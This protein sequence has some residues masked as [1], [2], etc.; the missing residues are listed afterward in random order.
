MPARGLTV[1][2]EKSP[3]LRGFL[4]DGRAGERRS[5]DNGKVFHRISLSRSIDSCRLRPRPF[6]SLRAGFMTHRLDV[7]RGRELS[8]AGAFLPSSGCDYLTELFETGRWRRFHSER[9]F[10]ENIQEA[11]SA[12]ETWRDLL[13]R[14]ASRDNSAVDISWLGRA[15]ATLPPYRNVARSGPSASVAAGTE[16]GRTAVTRS[17]RSARKPFT[18]RSKEAP[19]A[20]DVPALVGVETSPPEPTPD[21]VAMHERYPLLRNAL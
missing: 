1:N 18:C 7:A 14:E 12:V 4:S 21:I 11:K 17:S 9:A 16:P 8:R 19:S 5:L 20:P 3:N 6:F 13:T 10:L 2:S 15:G